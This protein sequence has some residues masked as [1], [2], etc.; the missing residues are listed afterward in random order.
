[1]NYQHWQEISFYLNEL[2]KERIAFEKNDISAETIEPTRKKMMTLL[3]HL[4]TSL[5]LRIDKHHTSLIIFAIVA[6]V[7]EKMQSYDYNESRVKWAPL[8]KDF[9]SAFNAGEIFFK[10]LDEI[11]DDPNIPNIVYQVFYSMLK[12]GFQGKYRESKTQI[13]KYLDMLKDKIPTSSH[14]HKKE[15]PHATT[16]KQKE[17]FL[18]KWHYYCFSG[19]L[20]IALFAALQLYS[21]LT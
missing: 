15:T 19:A 21:R 18:K 16:F 1:M 13:A 6:A 9:Y 11:L 8:Q 20:C 17:G 7:D 12:R 10:S 2:D 3:E 14:T 5:E 4:K